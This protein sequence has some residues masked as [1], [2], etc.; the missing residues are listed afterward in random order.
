MSPTTVTNNNIELS[1]W[2]QLGNF[3]SLLF[4]VTQK[5]QSWCWKLYL[6][7]IKFDVR[8]HML[9]FIL[10]LILP[11]LVPFPW[12][13]SWELALQSVISTINQCEFNYQGHYICHW[14]GQTRSVFSLYLYYVVNSLTTVDGWRENTYPIVHIIY[15][16]SLPIKRH[17]N[18]CNMGLWL[19]VYYYG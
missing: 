17:V 2:L 18:I 19:Y 1:F 3:M 9:D 6:T 15:A 12:C 8:N 4:S 14:R 7:K 16:I 5:C 13:F 11:S 10:Y